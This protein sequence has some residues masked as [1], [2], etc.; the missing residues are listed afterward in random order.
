MQS[1]FGRILF[2]IKHNEARMKALGFATV[3]YRWLCYVF[4]GVICGLAGF[5]LGNFTSF[6]SP[7]MLDWSDS[8]DL[9]FMLIIGG[10][11]ALFAP[12]TGALIFLFAQEWLSALTI[13]WHLIFGLLLIALV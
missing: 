6:I 1:P 13:Y 10:V 3:R 9:I 5:L 12:I 11:G 4:S 7:E 8:A 2:A